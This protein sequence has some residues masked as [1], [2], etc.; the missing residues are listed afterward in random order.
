M[1]PLK[2][3]QRTL[4][5][6]VSENVKRKS[7]E[8]LDPRAVKTVRVV[9]GMPQIS[10]DIPLTAAELT[11]TTVGQRS[12]R[13]LDRLSP[14][15][16]TGVSDRIQTSG[17]GSHWSGHIDDH[18]AGSSNLVTDYEA[19]GVYGQAELQGVSAMAAPIVT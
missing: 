18:I 11:R 15:R 16:G 12:E 2:K 8:P 7:E 3:L 19:D 5:T 17:F 9:N 14:G 1:L 13:A 10:Y 4:Q 6:Y